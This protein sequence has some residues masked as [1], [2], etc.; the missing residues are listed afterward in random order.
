[1]DKIVLK[2]QKTIPSSGWRPITISGDIWMQ[3][4]ELADV[5][6]ISKNQIA[7]TLLSAALEI[8]E[9]EETP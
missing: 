7:C 1:M 4:Q 5:T 6:G 9:V 2:K 3:I 8:V